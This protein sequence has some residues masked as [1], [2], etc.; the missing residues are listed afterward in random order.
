MVHLASYRTAEKARKGWDQAR[1]ENR[2]LLGGLG[3]ELVKIDLGA[4]IGEF[5][6]VLAGAFTSEEKARTL[7]TQL[8]ARGA[9]CALVF[10]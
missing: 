1:E 6:R 2:D 3:V 9:F 4:G 10:N 5:F 7:C 8:K